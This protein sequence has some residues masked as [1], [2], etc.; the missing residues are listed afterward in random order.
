M[1]FKTNVLARHV[2]AVLLLLFS[3]NTFAQKTVTG[4]ITSNSD[5][6]ALPGATVQV[7]G[8]KTATQTGVDG[9]FSIKVPRD[10]S[11]L[12][13][14][15]VGFEK[16]EIGLSGK[17]DLG[18]IPL[19]QSTSTLNDVVVTGYTV[20]RKKD[21]TGA[22]AVIDVTDAK[23][24]PVTSSEQL[25]QGQASGVTVLNS[26]APGA[27]ST[28]LVRGVSNFGQTQP[29]YVVDGVQVSDMSTVNPNDIESISVLKDAGSAAIYGISGGNGVVVITTKKGKSGKS[30][31]NYDG[32]YGNQQPLSGNVWHLMNP[33]Q[34]SIVAFRA[35]D[36]TTEAA[37]YPGGAGVL[38][39]YGYHGPAGSGGTFGPQGVT[40]DPNVL[41]YYN[42]DANN[43]NND[44]LVQKFSTTGTDWFHTIFKAAPSQSH[45]LSA[46]GGN[47]RSTYYLSASYL[48]QQGTLLNTY[49]KRMSV[50]VNTTFNV[51]DHVRFGEA[52]YITFRNNEGGYNGNQQNEGGSISYTYRT[53]PIIPQF[54]VKGNY[55]GTFDSPAG[56]P[57]GN[58]SQPYAIQDRESTHHSR[59]FTVE[60]NVFA[61]ADFLKN[62]T[63]RTSFGGL[64]YNQYYWGI[65]YNTYNDY[66]SHGSANGAN[67]NEQMSQQYNWTNTIQYKQVFGKHNIQAFAGYEQKQY[68]GRSFSAGTQN[69]FSLDPNYVQ[70][71]FGSQALTP[72]TS[73]IYQPT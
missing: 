65:G 33:V 6:Q 63:A 60:G 62:F 11:I 49:E 42:F 72:A 25:L 27:P 18:E 67:E 44:F 21:I 43:P 24:I 52:G 47:D 1:P 13:I 26:G 64:L 36:V 66:E 37:L 23:K 15:V 17:T 32:Y 19:V 55:G 48:D 61:E 50:R 29:L 28:V 38:P 20:Q 4:K 10:N 7:K 53:M 12:S 46:S 16:M 58:A 35:N 9:S 54:D 51:K 31:I 34:Q 68:G 14:S 45:T 22:V 2:L 8:T 41:Q 3:L 40:N 59:F 70:L 30:V 56:E 71:Q 73:T 69:L 39:I 5:K 57:L